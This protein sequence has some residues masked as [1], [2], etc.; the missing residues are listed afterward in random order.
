[1][2]FDEIKLIQRDREKER[3]K[4]KKL[5]HCIHWRMHLADTFDFSSTPRFLFE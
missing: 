1:M 4:G 2:N 3:E 5:F